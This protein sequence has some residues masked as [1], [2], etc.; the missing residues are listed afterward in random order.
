MIADPDTYF[1]KGCD[2]CR[3]FDTPECKV[4]LW[5]EGLAELRQ[6]CRQTELEEGAKWGQPVYMIEGRNVCLISAFNDFFFLSF[7]NAALMSDPKQLLMKRG[8]NTQDPHMLTF[9]SA[10]EVSLQNE[11]IS[12]YLA[13]A[14]AYAKAGKKAPKKDTQIQMPQELLDALDR[15]PELAEAFDALTPGRQRGYCIHIGQAKQS[16]TRETRIE[17]LRPRILAGKG[18]NE[19]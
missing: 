11:T 17:K 1:E 14:I 2:R 13:E 16:K 9:T 8:A 10:D 18:Y 3:K 15:D 6:I 5:R 12:A 19:R 4:N 7:F